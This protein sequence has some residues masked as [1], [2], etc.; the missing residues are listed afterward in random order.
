WRMKKEDNMVEEPYEMYE[1]FVNELKE[2]ELERKRLLQKHFLSLPHKC[3][4]V[5]EMFVNETPLK[6]IAWRLGYKN[7]EYA[8][9]RKYMCKSM[10]RKRIL[11][12][13][14]FKPFLRNGYKQTIG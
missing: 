5:L 14:K 11:N 6:E 12:D 1:H 2:E 8:K 13:P 9:S 3:Q 10:L 4:K 7:E